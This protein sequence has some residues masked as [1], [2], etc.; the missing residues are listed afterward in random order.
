VGFNFPG[1]LWRQ[2]WVKV[3]ALEGRAL[4]DREGLTACCGFAITAAG[5]RRTAGSIRR[6]QPRALQVAGSLDPV[7]EARETGSDPEQGQSPKL[8][9][10][11]FGCGLER[12]DDPLVEEKGLSVC[13]ACGES[14]MVIDG[15]PGRGPHLWDV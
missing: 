4:H 7:R 10:V 8:R 13:L 2:E 15:R 11:C 3:G 1:S 6:V 14:R 9:A 12:A 5:S